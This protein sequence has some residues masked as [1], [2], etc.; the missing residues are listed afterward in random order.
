M[1]NDLKR[2]TQIMRPTRQ[3]HFTF[4][5]R[6]HTSLTIIAIRFSSM[7]FRLAMKGRRRSLS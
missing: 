3:F 6:T 1:A 2:L 7:R 4:S 5:K